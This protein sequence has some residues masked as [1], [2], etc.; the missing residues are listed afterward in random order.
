VTPDELQAEVA[1]LE[2]LDCCTNPQPI[3]TERELRDYAYEVLSDEHNDLTR[4]EMRRIEDLQKRLEPPEERIKAERRAKRWAQRELAKRR[5]IGLEGASLYALVTFY[6]ASNTTPRTVAPWPK[7]GCSRKEKQ[8]QTPSH[9]C[10][11]GE[12]NPSAQT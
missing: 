10:T 7:R 9:N 12:A 11:L 6:A 5:R 2:K 1:W 8:Q 4:S 3:T